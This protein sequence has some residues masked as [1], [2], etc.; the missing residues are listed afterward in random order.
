[1]TISFFMVVILR[2]KLFVM[3]IR[4]WIHQKADYLSY[5]IKMR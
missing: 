5:H 1:M 2:I 3:I 4:F